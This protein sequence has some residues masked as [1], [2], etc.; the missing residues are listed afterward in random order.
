MKETHSQP[1]LHTTS[2]SA[3]HAAR[4]GVAEARLGS[5][6]DGLERALD[7]VETAREAGAGSSAEAEERQA[8]LRNENAALQ[9]TQAEIAGRLDTAVDRLRRALAD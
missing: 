3:R 1:P 8:R 5:A 7:R 2:P 4:L 9:Q 6:L